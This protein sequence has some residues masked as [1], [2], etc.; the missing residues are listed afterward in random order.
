MQRSQSASIVSPERISGSDYSI[1]EQ[2]FIS[3]QGE[4]VRV[5]KPF[6]DRE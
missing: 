2:K 3:S 4:T 1:I 6:L 5:F